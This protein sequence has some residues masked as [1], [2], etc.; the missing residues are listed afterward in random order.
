[1]NER[2]ICIIN[3]ERDSFVD[4]PGI[5]ST[6]FIKGCNLRCAWCHNPESQNAFPELMLYPEKCTRCGKCREICAHPQ[7]CI[8]C[9][10]CVSVCTNGAR[11]LCGEYMTA[12]EIMDRVRKDRKFYRMS[13]GGITFSGGECML[14]IDALSE[15]LSACK[16][17]G[18]HTAVDTAGNVPFSAFLK[19]EPFT[20]LFLYDV[21][22]MDSH[23]HERFTGVGNEL[24]LNN[25]SKLL[26]GKTPVWI[27]MPIVQ[28][29]N[30]S[31]ENILALA[32]FLKEYGM[33][34]QIELL[35]YHRLGENKY[36]ALGRE[37]QTFDLVSAS[38]LD[39]LRHLLEQELDHR[40]PV[41]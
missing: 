27:R 14:Q 26:S 19:I 31:K 37:F 1:M 34:E 11:E 16:Q 9:G 17:E 5:R 36:Q 35:P 12:D 22:S 21:K 25:L 7:S 6:V 30:D 28:N 33:P 39:T 3:I 29:A 10:D 20:D 41:K 38:K 18:F 40:I 23:I 2:K 24:I 32:A 8:L 13:G 15:L 4:G